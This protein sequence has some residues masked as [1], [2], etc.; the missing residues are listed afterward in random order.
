VAR[1]VHLPHPDPGPVAIA[2]SPLKG[3]HLSGA[4]RLYHPS[5]SGSFESAELSRIRASRHRYS[6]AWLWDERSGIFHRIPLGTASDFKV[7]A[8]I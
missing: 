5:R 8:P 2:N 4:M 6:T 7:P 1:A 3:Q